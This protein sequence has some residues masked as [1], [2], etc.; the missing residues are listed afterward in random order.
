MIIY[1]SDVEG[2]WDYFNRFVNNSKGIKW[3]K[4]NAWIELKSGYIFV[5][6]GDVM[7]KGVGSLR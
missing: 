5:Y 7:D 1:C 6:G 2:N 3:N 4:H